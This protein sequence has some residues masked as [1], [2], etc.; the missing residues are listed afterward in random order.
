[1]RIALSVFCTA[2]VSLIGGAQATPI[3]FKA[4][5]TVLINTSTREGTVEVVPF[6]ERDVNSDGRMT[7]SDALFATYPEAASA[8]L[9]IP[10]STVEPVNAN[11]WGGPEG[12]DFI[13]A[14]NGGPTLIVISLD[15]VDLAVSLPSTSP[16]ISVDPFSFVR[17]YYFVPRTSR[18]PSSPRQ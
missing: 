4:T 5:R 6:D 17:P 16:L 12:G 10:S 13:Q 1:M 11:G 7:A 14:D 8:I 18:P 15:A 2:V 9:S 3:A